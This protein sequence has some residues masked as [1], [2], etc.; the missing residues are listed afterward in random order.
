MPQMSPSYGLL[1]TLP[2][3]SSFFIQ[4]KKTQDSY[5]NMGPISDCHRSGKHDFH[6]KGLLFRDRAWEELIG[7][8]FSGW[9]PTWVPKAIYLKSKLWQNFVLTRRFRLLLKGTLVTMQNCLCVF[10]TFPPLAQRSPNN[11]YSKFRAPWKSW[12]EADT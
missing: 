1:I 11:Y 8:G 9:R 7:F 4:L 2:S 3:S 6:S 10:D 5:L 12:L